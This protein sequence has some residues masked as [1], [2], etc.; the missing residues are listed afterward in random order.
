MHRESPTHATVI[1]HPSTITNVAV[2]PDRC[3][4]IEKPKLLIAEVDFNS[5]YCTEDCLRHNQP[6]SQNSLSVFTKPETRALGRIDS[7]SSLLRFGGRAPITSFS[8]FSLAYVAA[9]TPL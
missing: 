4:E 2:V 9:A 5:S 6:V 7:H 1:V 3:S 8:R